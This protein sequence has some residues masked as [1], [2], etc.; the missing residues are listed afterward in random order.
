[1][2]LSFIYFDYIAVVYVPWFDYTE[3]FFSVLLLIDI[4][5]NSFLFVWVLF[6]VRIVLL[7]TFLYMFLPYII[8]TLGYISRSETDGSPV[9]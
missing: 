2:L 6:P 5:V 3:T 1:M 8:C 4:W 7:R 9:T